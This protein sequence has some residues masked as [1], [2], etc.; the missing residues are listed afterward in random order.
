MAE[1]LIVIGG[2]AAGL[3]AA[4]KLKRL[5]PDIEILVF[6]KSGYVSYGSCGLPYFVGDLIKEPEDLVSLTVEE[7]TQKRNI[8]TYIHH[9]VTSIDR[10][11]KTVTV[12]DMR[13]G[14]DE[15]HSYTYLV[16]AT[17][18]VPIVPSIQ[19]I[20]AENVFYLRN[21]EDGIAL[22]HKMKHQARR[23]VIIGGGF[24]G[25]EV[26]E[27]FR[28]SG[29]EVHLFEQMPR[30]L[31]FLHESFSAQALAVL[32]KNKVEVSLGTMI[33][34]IV[35]KDGIATGVRTAD[36]I[37]YE[38][39]CILLSVGVLPNSRL[40]KQAGLETGLKGGI[41]VDEYMNTSDSS[42]WACGDC[43]QMFQLITGRPVYVPLGTTAN[44]Q[45]RIAGENIA[46]AH[47]AFKGVLGSQ[48][49]KIFELFMGSTGL[50]SAQAAE[51]DF[52]AE[53][54]VIKKGD[55]ASYY[56]GGGDNQICLVF[57]KAGGR[58]LGAQAIGSETIAGRLNVLA[59]A[60]TCKMTIDEINELD[61]VY[62]P[63]VAPV[64]DPILI[65]AGQALK[66]VT[67]GK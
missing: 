42:I 22:K 51:A 23:A 40:A 14:L 30:L 44:K 39:D 31:P 41:V 55:K 33:A 48:I 32:E 66:K 24:I 43:V 38:A 15:S 7:L 36:G 35:Q 50:S 62:A 6:E 47:H 67:G 4:S 29:L 52:D 2:T 16:I 1:R 64:Y 27:A 61:F 60:I 8:Q 3:S 12:R 17:G 10:E 25:L 20:G 18:G 21:V 5:K 53:T 54:V 19:G 65:A 26:A 45:G 63:P 13:T 34:E 37:Y 28:L 49:T 59:T 57:E 11:K 9:E 56:P 46:G 58:L